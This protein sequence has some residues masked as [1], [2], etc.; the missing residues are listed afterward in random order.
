MYLCTFHVHCPLQ[1]K[2]SVSDLRVMLMNISEFCEVSK[3]KAMLS[4]QECMKF[5]LCIY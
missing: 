2:F 5:H 1:V 3:V 4:L